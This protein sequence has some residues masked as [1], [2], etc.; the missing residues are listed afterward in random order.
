VRQQVLDKMRAAGAPQRW[1]E[2]VESVVQMQAEDQKRSLG[3]SL[4]PGLVLL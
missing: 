2:L 1:I 4:P 3:D